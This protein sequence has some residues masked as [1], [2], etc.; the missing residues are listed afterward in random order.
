MPNH[1]KC[2]LWL[3][4]AVVAAVAAAGFMLLAG[5]TP[6][7]AEPMEPPSDPVV[8]VDDHSNMAPEINEIIEKINDRQ[9]V[10]DEYFTYVGDNEEIV[11]KLRSYNEF[12]VTY[13][14]FFYDRAAVTMIWVVMPEKD[15]GSPDISGLPEDVLDMI[16]RVAHYSL[17]KECTQLFLDDAVLYPIIEK[18]AGGSAGR[19]PYVWHTEYLGDVPEIRDGLNE[20][21]KLTEELVVQ[22]EGYKDKL[23]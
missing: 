7:P 15:T 10:E 17:Y 16:E 4:I 23:N 21:F 6:M 18:E 3:S 1:K 22:L 12:T 9:I 8:E 20:Y 13:Y 11:E 19:W 14:K 2:A 5:R